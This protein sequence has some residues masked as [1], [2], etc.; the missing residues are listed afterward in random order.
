MQYI[1]RDLADEDDI[2]ELK[3]IIDAMLDIMHMKGMIDEEADCWNVKQI[4]NDNRKD[5]EIDNAETISQ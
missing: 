2:E 5:W 4:R 1:G 3:E